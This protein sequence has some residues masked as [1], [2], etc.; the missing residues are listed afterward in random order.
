MSLKKP[1]K[2]TFVV[3]E[4]FEL[5]D[6]LIGSKQISSHE[7][8]EFWSWWTGDADHPRDER[9]GPCDNSIRYVPIGYWGWTEVP[10]GLSDKERQTSPDE[11]YAEPENAKGKP[12]NLPRLRNVHQVLLALQQ[13]CDRMGD[14]R[15]HMAW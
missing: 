10:K 12:H 1:E 7:W 5:R 14:L 11:Y 4:L 8:D 6:Y 9:T 15:V 3:Y 2:K 13:F